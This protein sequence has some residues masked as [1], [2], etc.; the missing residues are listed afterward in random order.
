MKIL[1]IEDSVELADLIRYT[2]PEEDI[3][4][5]STLSDACE[6][7]GSNRP[8]LILVDLGLPDSKG[9][10]TLMG[11]SRVR[12][13]KVVVTANPDVAWA[14][15]EFGGSDYILKNSDGGIEELLGRIGFNIEKYRPKMKPKFTPEVFAELKGCLSLFA[16]EKLTVAG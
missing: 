11:L 7:L 6:W 5:C 3:T 4:V 9:L 13:P 15:T 14:I 12:A 1:L 10:D 2:Y 8:N 16:S